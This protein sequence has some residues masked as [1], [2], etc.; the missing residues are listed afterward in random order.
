V[1]EYLI[2]SGMGVEVVVEGVILE[3]MKIDRNGG[4]VSNSVEGGGGGGTRVIERDG[5]GGEVD[6]VIIGLEG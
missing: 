4:W 6:D 3:G 1:E 5:G 2:A